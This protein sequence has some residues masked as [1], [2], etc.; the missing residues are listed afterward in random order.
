MRRVKRIERL[1]VSTVHDDPDLGKSRF[2]LQEA[3]E[4]ER[5]VEYR[6][7]NSVRRSGASGVIGLI[8]QQPVKLLPNDG[9]AMCARNLLG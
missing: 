1:E 5:E 6:R 2:P 9:G 8:P 7:V 4:H 3:V